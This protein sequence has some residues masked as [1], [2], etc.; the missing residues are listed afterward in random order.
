PESVDLDELAVAVSRVLPST[1]LPH[2]ILAWSA[3][4]L[5][6]SGK[7]DRDR[8]RSELLAGASPRPAHRPPTDALTR[9]VA[10]VWR[11][12]LGVERI[13]LDDSFFAL[14]GHSLDAAAMILRLESEVGRRLE[15]ASLF[16]A[17]RLAAFAELVRAG[18]ERRAGGVREAASSGRVHGQVAR[19][20]G[21]Q[22]LL[23][24]GSRLRIHGAWIAQGAYDPERLAGA[25]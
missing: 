23:G 3:L 14:G 21:V 7:I 8:V 9:T 5:T 20:L 4:P 13:G 18:G 22:G 12:V 2:E 25:F 15:L 11:Q 17:P 1:H 16:E 6:A 10:R 24:D 19:L